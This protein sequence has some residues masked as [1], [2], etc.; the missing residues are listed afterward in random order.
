MIRLFTVGLA[1]ALFAGAGC[2]S[3]AS[4]R[5]TYAARP[6]LAAPACPCPGGAAVA[7]PSAVAVSPAV[8]VP[9]PPAYPRY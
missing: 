9:P 1:C 5:S 4:Y 6:V 3:S 2:H 8:A 7:V